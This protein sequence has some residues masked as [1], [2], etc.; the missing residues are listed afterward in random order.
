MSLRPWDIPRPRLFEY[1]NAYQEIRRALVHSIGRACRLCQNE[2]SPPLAGFGLI[3]LQYSGL[4]SWLFPSGFCMRCFVLL[5]PSTLGNRGIHCL[6][7]KQY[8]PDR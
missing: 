4:L 1:Q 5:N 3:G 2:T 6:A 7:C 8:I